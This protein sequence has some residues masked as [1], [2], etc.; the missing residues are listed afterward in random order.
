[1]SQHPD[2]L[3]DGPDPSHPTIRRTNIDKDNP[4]LVVT[5]PFFRV[6]PDISRAPLDDYTLHGYESRKEFREAIEYLIRRWGRRYG[7]C[8]E[9]RTYHA[10]DGSVA[11]NRYK[12]LHL[13][14]RDVPGCG[15]EEAWLPRYLLD[16]AATPSYAIPKKLST[17]EQ[18]EQEIQDALWDIRHDP[19]GRW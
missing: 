17:L 18:Q 7:E 14:F 11:D 3:D 1:M 9:E 4:N 12:Q 15:Y 19:Y 16:P 10:P 5:G 13:R 2:I 6:E 8:L